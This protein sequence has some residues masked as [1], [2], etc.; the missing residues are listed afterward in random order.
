MDIGIKENYKE[1]VFI[2]GQ[3]DENLMEIGKIMQWMGLEFIHGMMV[4]N[5]KEIIY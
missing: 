5:I 3:M 1:K 4:E 2:F